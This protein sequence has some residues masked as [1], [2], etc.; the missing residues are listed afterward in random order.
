MVVLMW[1]RRAVKGTCGGEY[2][3]EEKEVQT[4]Y[5]GRMPTKRGCP[6]MKFSERI[7]SARTSNGPVRTPSIPAWKKCRGAEENSSNRMRREWEELRRATLASQTAANEG[8]EEG[9]RPAR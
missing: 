7:S 3:G 6:I 1:Y 2:P 9:W 4:S 8:S 5:C